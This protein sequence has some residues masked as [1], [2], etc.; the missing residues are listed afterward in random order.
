MQAAR[1]AVSRAFFNDG[2]N[3]DA[4]IEMIATTTSNSIRVKAK[5]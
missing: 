2:S 4:R 1:F 3:S 5:R